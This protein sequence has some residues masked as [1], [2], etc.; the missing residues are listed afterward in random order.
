MIVYFAQIN[1]HFGRITY[2]LLDGS[3]LSDSLIINK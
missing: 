3:N 1:N 2:T